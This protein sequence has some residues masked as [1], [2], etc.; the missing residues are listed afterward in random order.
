MAPHLQTRGRLRL[1]GTLAIMQSLERAP[2]RALVGIW[3]WRGAATGS[4]AAVC[5]SWLLPPP[6]SRAAEPGHD[7]GQ[8]GVIVRGRQESEASLG[9]PRLPVSWLGG[10]LPDP[11]GTEPSAGPWSLGRAGR[12]HARCSFSLQLCPRQGHGGSLVRGGD[13]SPWRCVGVRWPRRTPPHTLLGRPGWAG[14]LPASPPL[15]S[16]LPCA[17]PVDPGMP[18]LDSSF[19]PTPGTG[20]GGL[21]ASGG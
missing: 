20:W 18:T 19:L 4:E 15:S 6:P 9:E 11:Q 2:P 17:G 13:R 3:A 8:L 21:D 10:L 5:G 1:S 16:Q 7:Q 14:R 12:L